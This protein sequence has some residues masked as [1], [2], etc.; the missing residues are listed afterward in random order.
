MIIT[1]QQKL[2]THNITLPAGKLMEKLEDNPFN[3][4]QSSEDKE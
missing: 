2:D 3:T 4:D 1:N